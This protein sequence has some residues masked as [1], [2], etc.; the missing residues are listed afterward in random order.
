[1]MPLQSPL[2]S[3]S[4]LIAHGF[5]GRRGG[6]SEGVFAS[7]NCGFGSADQPSHVQANRSHVAEWLGTDFEHLLTVYQVHSAEVVHVTGAWKREESPRADGMVTNV[8]GIALGVLAADC[9]PV[10]FADAE[11]GVIGS[12]HAGWQGAFKGVVEAVVAQ[13]ISLGAERNRIRACI[14]PCISQANYE[15]G[16]EFHERFQM[17]GGLNDRYFVRS[18]REGHWMFDLPGYVLQRLS[19]AGVGRVQS[20][21]ACTYENEGEYFS[22]RRTTHRQE[23]EYGRNISAIMLVR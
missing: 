10:L 13:M 4:K 20:L 23:V 2:L 14:G 22:F 5:F 17:V 6:V 12:A 1:M 15:V 19:S 3:N 9:A 16:P 8:P 7:L 18:A 21:G 11:A